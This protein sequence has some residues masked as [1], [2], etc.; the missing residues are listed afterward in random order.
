M[1]YTFE[2]EA[3]YDLSIDPVL[4]AKKLIK[5][6][7]ANLKNQDMKILGGKNKQ[8]INKSKK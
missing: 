4:F 7:L 8:I 3:Q 1:T 6:Y 2:I 5:P